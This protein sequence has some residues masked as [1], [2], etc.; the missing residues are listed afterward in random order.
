MNQDDI[1]DKR[2]EL[3]KLA[4]VKLMDSI[5]LWIRALV[6]LARTPTRDDLLLLIN[7]VIYNKIKPLLKSALNDDADWDLVYIYSIRETSLS[8]SV[9][10]RDDM[11]VDKV[12]EC[13]AQLICRELVKMSHSIME[14][15][16]MD[17]E[18]VIRN[19][20][21]IHKFIYGY[22]MGVGGCRECMFR[23]LS[24]LCEMIEN[25]EENSYK[26]L[27]YVMR[28]EYLITHEYHIV[29]R[30]SYDSLLEDIF[31]H[32]DLKQIPCYT[33][34]NIRDLMRRNPN[35]YYEESK[36]QFKVYDDIFIND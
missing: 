31:D 27:D 36:I 34:D 22:P 15:I 14:E 32:I 18:L 20:M 10:F 26:L 16:D 25:K 29:A 9:D 30:G 2:M 3:W 28:G 23:I 7:G 11:E 13:I 33:M 4:N 35:Y 5:D 24:V 1:A 6:R 12:D 8:L 21:E 17:N 19:L